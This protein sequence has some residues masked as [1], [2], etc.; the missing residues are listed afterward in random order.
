MS[1]QVTKVI[2]RTAR[3][4]QIAWFNVSYWDNHGKEEEDWEI[5]SY[6]DIDQ[7]VEQFKQEERNNRTEKVLSSLEV[8]ILDKF[9]QHLKNGGN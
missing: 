2:H 4:V 5:D 3:M 7:A 1:N 9:V 8:A 6:Q